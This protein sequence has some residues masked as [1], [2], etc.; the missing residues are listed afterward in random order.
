MKT[1]QMNMEHRKGKAFLRYD[2]SKF[3]VML[4]RTGKGKTKRS[5]IPMVTSYKAPE[6]MT[7]TVYQYIY[8]K[9]VFIAYR[10]LKTAWMQV[11]DTK[12]ND[13]GNLQDYSAKGNG[14]PQKRLYKLMCECCD[15]SS[16]A[17]EDFELFLAS[18]KAKLIVKETKHHAKG[19]GFITLEDGKRIKVDAGFTVKWSDK[20]SER[21]ALKGNGRIQKQV[22]HTK[23]FDSAL[24]QF[25][26]IEKPYYTTEFTEYGQKWM[27]EY[28]IRDD[29]DAE[30]LIQSAFLAFLQL[31]RYGTLIDWNDVKLNERAGY[32]AVNHR[33]YIERRDA[34]KT[35]SYE[36]YENMLLVNNGETEFLE[37]GTIVDTFT[38]KVIS[39][40]AVD[41]YLNVDRKIIVDTIEKRLRQIKRKTFNVDECV[42]CFRLI[43]DGHSYRKTAEL[44]NKKLNQIQRYMQA[45]S[46]LAEDAETKQMLRD[47]FTTL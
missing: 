32:S 38:E 1:V 3:T 24:N 47:L 27:E 30:D 21:T 12:V 46:S 31:Y 42:H 13:D 9:C 2:N 26:P 16:D 4:C 23:R 37:D 19:D 11:K 36:Q 18:D 8:Q 44:M 15:I 14:N 20:T 39:G 6:E 17:K 33:I 29:F 41:N 10:A 34:P 28:K 40:K 25:V 43:T 35:I 22:L 45:V 5:S 7:N